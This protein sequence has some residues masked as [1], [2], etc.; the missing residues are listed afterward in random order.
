VNVPSEDTHAWV[1]RAACRNLNPDD[2]FPAATLTLANRQAIRTCLTECP[3]R[4]ECAAERRPTDQGIWGGKW[5]TTR[6]LPADL[7]RVAI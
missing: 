5:W 6:H 2:W 7:T 3:V 1:R 4:A